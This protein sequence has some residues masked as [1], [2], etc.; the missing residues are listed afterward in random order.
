MKLKQQFRPRYCVINGVHLFFVVRMDD[1]V[2]SLIA[3]AAALAM[4]GLHW[5]CASIAGV[6]KL[7]AALGTGKVIK[8]PANAFDPK[9]KVLHRLVQRARDEGAVLLIDAEF[10]QSFKFDS[11]DK[12]MDLKPQET[13]TV[14]YSLAANDLPEY[15]LHYPRGDRPDYCIAHAIGAIGEEDPED[16]DY[17]IYDRVPVWHSGCITSQMHEVLARCDDYRD[18]PPMPEVLC[19]YGPV[20]YCSL[21]NHDIHIDEVIQMLGQASHHAWK[22]VISHIYEEIA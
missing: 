21:I 8:L 4:H 2:I 3:L 1:S 6:E 12:A 17:E 19:T 18:L 22:H 7:E 10:D 15:S 13:L 9:S 20:P 5:L 16:V 11:L 14:I